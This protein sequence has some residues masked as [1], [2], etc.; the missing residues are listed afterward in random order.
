MNDVQLAK[1]LGLFSLVLGTVE[2]AAGRRISRAL[3]IGSPWLVRFC[4]AREVVAGLGVLTKPD[5]AG[6]VWSRV[7]GDAM[8]LSVLAMALGSHNRHRHNA[9]W[10]TLAVVG[11]T[12]L[13]V[14][15][16]ASLNRRSS[17]ALETARR[18]RVKVIQHSP[19]V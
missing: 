5:L 3:G 17:T 8:D 12:A 6:P 15:C 13:D 9:A 16:A 18:T 4:G 7:A 14:V 1:G 19:G 11:A 10:A 2:L